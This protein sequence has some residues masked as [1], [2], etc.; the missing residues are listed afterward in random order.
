[1]KITSVEA[2]CHTVP[3]QL[4]LD[5]P[6]KEHFVAVRVETDEGITGIGI[7]HNA[8]R[9]PLREFINRQL[10]PFLVG[11]NPLETERLWSKDAGAEMDIGVSMWDSSMV[12]RRGISAIDIAL[13][14][15]KGKRFKQPVFRL[16][17]GRSNRI[18]AYVTFGLNIYSRKELAEVARQFVQAGQKHLKMKVGFP[19]PGQSLAEDEAR[20]RAVREVIGDEG[21]LMVDGN[22]QFNFMQAREL[23]Q[24]IEA[25]RIALFEA[26]TIPDF[27]LLAALRRCTSIPITHGGTVPPMLWFFRELII[28][29]AVDY[30]QPNVLQVGGYTGA[31]KIAHMAESFGMP[32]ANGGGNPHHNM[33]LLAGV[34]NGWIVEFHYGHMLRDEVIFVDPPRFDHG[35][36]TLPEKPGLGLEINEDALKKYQE[37]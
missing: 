5:K 24:R 16:L 29:G 14:D 26:P 1:M 34:A 35:W 13:W 15:I 4:P 33:H 31:L 6:R 10:A 28:N 22:C 3:V 36:L 37:A 2:T 7:G 8:M 11:K 25:Y 9:F 23:A 32:V 12:V 21:L 20:V 30:I 17:G 18:P 27:R 19:W